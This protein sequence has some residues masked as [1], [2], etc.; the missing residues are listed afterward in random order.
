[1]V[2]TDYG[3]H[4]N[5]RNYGGRGVVDPRTDIDAGQVQRMAADLAAIG[6]VM[7]FASLRVIPN[8]T[9]VP[10]VYRAQVGPVLTSN[11]YVGNAPPAGMPTV[12][13]SNTDVYIVDFPATYTDEAGVTAAFS[14]IMA[15]AS[16]AASTGIG[17]A[18]AYISAGNVYV[19]TY[20]VS[21]SPV[22]SDAFPFVVEVW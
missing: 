15:A 7:P 8:G 4:A 17:T 9:G 13:R 16:I 3:G 18:S 21:G 11:G 22:A 20:D 6:R 5:K 12:T 10:T 1:M 19:Y 14:P 2:F